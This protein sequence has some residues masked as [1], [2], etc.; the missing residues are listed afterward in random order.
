MDL[1]EIQANREAGADPEVENDQKA[2]NDQEAI[3]YVEGKGGDP[4]VDPEED[5]KVDP[6]VMRNTDV[7][8]GEGIPE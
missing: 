4:E 3:Q 1:E 2:R 6:E 8:L 7:N 5:P